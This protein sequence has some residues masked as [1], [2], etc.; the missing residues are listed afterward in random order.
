MVREMMSLKDLDALSPLAPTTSRN[1][2]YVG[3]VFETSEGKT[4]FWVPEGQSDQQTLSLLITGY[5]RAVTMD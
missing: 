1:V 3:C 2:A 5:V 4:H